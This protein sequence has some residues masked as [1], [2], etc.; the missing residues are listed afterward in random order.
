MKNKLFLTILVFLLSVL[1]RVYYIGYDSINPDAV[2]WHYRCQQFSNGLK[3]FQFEKTYQHYHPGVTLCYA[4]TIPTELYRKFASQPVYNTS[5][6]QAFNV[7]NTVSVVIIVSFLI[8]FCFYQ[9][10]LKEGLVFVILQTLEPFYFGNSKIIH[11]DILHSL[12]VFLALM[13]FKKFLDSKLLKSLVISAFLLGLGFLT[14]SIT[15]IFLPIILFGLFFLIEKNKFKFLVVYG[16]TFVVT[17]F[18]LF[19][20]L[21]V[22]PLE[23]ITNIFSEASRVGINNGHSQIFLGVNFDED[24]NPGPLFYFV[25]MVV[26]FSPLLLFGLILLVGDIFKFL[27]SKIDFKEFKKFEVFLF[28]CY[29]AYL[30]VILYSNKKVDRYLLVIVPPLI[31]YLSTKI[32]HFKKVIIPLALVNLFSILYFSPTQFLYYSPILLNYSNVN[33]LVAQKSF[34]MGIYDLKQYLIKNY[35]ELRF[36]FYDI[37]PME[38]IYSNSKV[39][40]IREVGPGKVDVV[41]L[42]INEVLPEDYALIFTKK[43]SYFIKDIPLYDIYTKN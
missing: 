31:Y 35:G 32:N 7:V 5:N 18:A 43:E 13:Y 42:S 22:A 9:F 2:N 40:D 15:V 24:S 3:Y 38:A 8:A 36:G 25:D 4:M 10:N 12:F 26:K 39:L 21:W 30:A 41:V 16:L 20:A 14:K 17:V 27:Q 19:P 11:L 1:V 37:K 28:F 34:G 33:G 23:T 29:L 6:F